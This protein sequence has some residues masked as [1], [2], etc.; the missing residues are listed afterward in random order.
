MANSH[1]CV[2]IG[3][4]IARYGFPDGHPWNCQRMDS[5]WDE[6]TRQGLALGADRRDPVAADEA[7]LTTFHLPEYVATVKRLS[8]NGSGFL[9]HGDTPAFPGIY[10]A[11]SHV[12]GSSL[13]VA[14]Q[15]MAGNYRRGM[16]PIA[17]LHHAQP[18][19]AGG[20]CV[21]NDAAVVTRILR[22]A[23]GLKRIGYVDI[24]AHHGDGL[25]YPFEADPDFIFADIHEDG[26]HLYPWTGGADETGV[27]AAYGRKLNIPMEPESDDR[28]FFEAW[29]KIEALM[30]EHEPEFFIL[31]C[32]ADSLR[33]DPLTHL[34]FSTAA[35]SH[36][37][38]RLCALAEELGHGRVL[39][40]GG[41][42]YNLT[43]VAQG[44]SAVLR[45]LIEAP[46]E[47]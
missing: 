36:A 10:E 29:P 11:A 21:F 17:G 38:T 30:R 15:I 28:H 35:H 19:I 14:K 25:F 16:V 2:T 32:G 45:A 1:V 7:E 40:L 24:D 39:A 23:F 34:A 42:G 3:E 18:D 31:Q 41:G 44:W 43:N 37:A 9:D 47:N 22:K 33:N 20:F 5:F 4:A 12:V 13:D 26:R 46:I 27:G 8:D 6:A